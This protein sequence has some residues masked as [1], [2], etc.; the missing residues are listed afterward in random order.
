MTNVCILVSGA[1]GTG[2]ATIQR[3]APAFFRTHVGESAAFGTDEIYRI[4]DPDWS[5]NSGRLRDLCKSNCIQLALNLFRNNVRAV[6]IAGNALYDWRDVND[7]VQALRPV[8][9]V[10]HFT[11]TAPVADVYERVKRRGDADMHPQRWLGD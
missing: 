10:Y 5:Q 11:L 4:V 8:S 9:S 6:L 1:P 2:K 3:L 7:Y